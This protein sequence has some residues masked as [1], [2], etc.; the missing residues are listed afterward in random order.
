VDKKTSDSKGFGFV[1]YDMLD[2]ANHAIDAMNGFH[3]GSKRLKVQRKRVA[4]QSY[5]GAGQGQGQ[6]HRMHP[7]GMHGLG[8]HGPQGQG[9]QGRD[10]HDPHMHGPQ[11]QGMYGGNNMH[12][13]HGNQEFHG[14]QGMHGSREMQGQGNQGMHRD[15][16]GPP[17]MMGIPGPQGMRSSQMQGSREMHDPQGMHGSRD[18]SGPQGPPGILASLQEQVNQGILASP[19]KEGAQGT[20]PQE[21]GNQGMLEQINLGILAPPS[22]QE[23]FRERQE[24]PQGPPSA[25]DAVLEAYSSFLDTQEPQQQAEPQSPFA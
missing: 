2:S 17:R 13:S 8:M 22:P 5:G 14:P 21:Q 25:S 24:S 20:G 1:S 10:M 12:G 6:G 18:M 3:I 9:R 23:G 15:M 11:G 19:D 4:P 7:Q 16:H